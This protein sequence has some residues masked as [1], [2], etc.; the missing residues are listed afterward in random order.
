M[1]GVRN[2]IRTVKAAADAA[3]VLLWVIVMTTYFLGLHHEARR[4]ADA[5]AGWTLVWFLVRHPRLI[6]EF[7][8]IGTAA[9]AGVVGRRGRG[10][11]TGRR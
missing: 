8:F 3:L 9:S 7:A 5:A 2:V 4:L 11:S 10:N 1:G 6:L